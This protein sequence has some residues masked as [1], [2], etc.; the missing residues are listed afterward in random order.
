MN[1]LPDWYYYFAGAAD[2]IQGETIPS[3]KPNFFVYTRREPV[4]VVAGIIAWNSPLLLLSFKLGPALASGCTF[5]AK[6]ASQT[7]ASALEFAKL[8]AEAGFPPGVFNVITG[9]GSTTGR[10]LVRHPG[11]DKVAFTGSTETGIGVMKDAADHVAKVSLELGGK[12][13]NIVFADADISTAV[14]GAV[15]GIFAA[16]GQSCIAGSR[17]FVQQPIHDELIGRLVER[18]RTIKLGNPLRLETEMGPVAFKEQLEKIKDFIQIGLAEGGELITGGKQ[19]TDPE[20]RDG[21]FIE[22]TI[23]DNMDN[24]RRLAREEIFGPVLCAIPFKTEEEVIRLA[25]DTSYGLAAGIWTRD[26]QRAHRVAH[27][28]RAGTVWINAYRTLSFT[29]P[30][31]G[32]KM[33]GLGKENGLEAL[34]EY[35][36]VK[37]VWVEL[38][39]LT[40]DPFKVG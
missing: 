32:Y 2:K 10:A 16:T 6:T 37:S 25:N 4:G 14:N 31:G 30:F 38:Q 21:Y 22:P 34:K 35:T 11:V 5:V 3:D 9:P 29:T 18:A 8:V 19:P 28:V 1:G 36:Q 40:R 26:L 20:L 23:F 13:P 24:H 15:A 17:L 39:G 12:S 33:S 7:P 27:A